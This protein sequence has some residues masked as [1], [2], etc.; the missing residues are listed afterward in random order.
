M[1]DVIAE[2]DLWQLSTEHVG[3]KKGG[4]A[5]LEPESKVEKS[6]KILKALK[7]DDYKPV[8]PCHVV[9][10][11]SSHASVGC[12]RVGAGEAP[13]GAA[14][15]ADDDQAVLGQSVAGHQRRD[16]PLQGML[17]PYDKTSVTLRRWASSCCGRTCVWQRACCT[18]C[19]MVTP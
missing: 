3:D 11:A 8:R 13:A 4:V 19:S 17:L 2:H 12:Q 5:P 14:G 1:H 18:A 7:D 9:F 10:C 15:A 16:T 6:V